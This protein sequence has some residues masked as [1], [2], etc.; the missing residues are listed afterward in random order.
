[1]V[2][3]SA[4]NE[5]RSRVVPFWMALPSQSIV[6]KPDTRLRPGVSAINHTIRITMEIP[7]GNSREDNKARKQIIKDFYAKWIAEHPDKKVW[8]HSLKSFIHIKGQSINET[9]GHA[10]L[11]FESTEAVLRIT[12]VLT[13]A[14]AQ[15][16]WRPKYGD[17]NQK[18]YSKMCLLRWKNC[19]LIV[20]YQKSKNEWVQYYLGSE[21]KKKA[22]R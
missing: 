5:T 2:V 12:E 3:E 21:Q 20:G 13:N 19:R 10:S 18:P 15:E 17:K 16:S 11:S 8:N 6:F 14:T 9:A 7:R 4:V 22:V 1:M